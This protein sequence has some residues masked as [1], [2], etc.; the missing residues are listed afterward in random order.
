MFL[1]SEPGMYKSDQALLSTLFAGVSVYFNS[2]GKSKCL[3][4]SDPDQIGSSMWDFQVSVPRNCDIFQTID[5][6]TL[7]F[8][9]N[10]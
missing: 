5:R 3:Q 2:T 6:Y 10:V 4:L 7:F 8:K 1:A 9:K